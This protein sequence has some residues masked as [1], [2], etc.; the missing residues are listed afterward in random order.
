M[1]MNKK[2]AALGLVTFLS[3]AGNLYFSGHLLGRS[4][5]G[6]DCGQSSYNADKKAEWKKKDHELRK[7]MTPED[8]AIVKQSMMEKREAFT[9]KREALDAARDKVFAAMSADDFDK[10][11]LDAAL[12]EEQARKGDMLMLIRDA[13]METMKKLSPKGQEAF[14]NIRRTFDADSMR[15]GRDGDRRIGQGQLLRKLKERMDDAE[16]LPEPQPEAPT[17][18]AEPDKP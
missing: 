4:M 15:S 12:A 17:P 14:K 18:P 7:S 11:T 1:Q 9:E 6:G 3:L 13:K 16:A 10:A 8:R 5:G 2:I